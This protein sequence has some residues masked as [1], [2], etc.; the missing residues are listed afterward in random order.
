[1]V[2]VQGDEPL[3]APAMIDEAVEVVVTS[4]AVAGTLVK[5]IESEH[6]LLNPSVVK[7]VLAKNGNC[8]YF[9]RAPIPFRRERAD[10]QWFSQSTYYKHIGIYVYRREFLLRYAMLEQSPLEVSEK[11]E[12]L[13]V[14]E[15]GFT[16]KAAVTA[17]DSIAVD[18][19]E[20]L[21]NVR[22]MFSRIHE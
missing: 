8:L 1:V 2:N 20:D 21:Q 19:P 11:L 22:Q 9:S 17:Y 4:S 5:R 14:L 6:E 12:Q 7:V 10:H 3:I 16:M 15:H 18:T 13:R